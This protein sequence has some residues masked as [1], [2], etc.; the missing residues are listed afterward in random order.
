MKALRKKM[1]Y[2][3]GDWFLVPLRDG[4]TALGL[5]ARVSKMGGVALGYFFARPP[6]EWA[7]AT[8]VL[9][10]ED[11][12]LVRMFGDLHLIDGSWR[13]LAP[14][15][16]WVR[17]RWPLPKFGRVDEPSGPAWIV[18]YADDDPSCTLR[19]TRCNPDDARSLPED[20]LAGAGAVEIVLTRLL[21]PL[22]T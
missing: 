22:P 8:A 18:E 21:R 4:G 6:G 20:G 1:R 10:P 16:E 19:E 9:R 13:I 14:H 7:E 12:V 5:A 17:Q 3:E 11:A 15:G 2:Q